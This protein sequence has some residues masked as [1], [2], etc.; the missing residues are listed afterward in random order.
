MKFDVMQNAM[1]APCSIQTQ[2][3]NQIKQQPHIYYNYNYNNYSSEVNH[4]ENAFSSRT[5][6]F[7]FSTCHQRLR[8]S[9]QSFF[10][11]F[12]FDFRSKSASIRFRFDL[13]N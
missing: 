12:R 13:F 4:K 1:A 2:K 7:P 11:F 9:F 5:S 10:L 8:L 6:H 3:S